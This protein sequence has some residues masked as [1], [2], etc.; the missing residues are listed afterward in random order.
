MIT[1]IFQK[2]KGNYG[3][4]RVHLELKKKG[5]SLDPKTVLKL[6]TEL[7]L[8]G[9]QKTKLYRSYKDDV[10]HVADNLVNRKFE[11]THPNEI[12]LTDVTE[13][14]VDGK[15]LYLSAIIDVFNR[16]IIGHSI[17]MNPNFDLVEASFKQA[18]KH[19][20]VKDHN[21]NTIIHSDQ[22]WLYQIKSFDR[23]LTPFN[24]YK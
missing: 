22:G 24:M 21:L 16:E 9:R 23:L 11:A 3:Y 4:R 2:H 1:E 12:W 13:F 15:K 19:I 5:H 10:G 14:K 18:T 17:S 20:N 6:M 8:K 7:D